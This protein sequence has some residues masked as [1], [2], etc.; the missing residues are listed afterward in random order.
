MPDKAEIWIRKWRIYLTLFLTGALFVGDLIAL[1]NTYLNGEI[2]T[3][4]I[5]KVIIILFI[6]GAIFKYYFFSIN[7]NIKWPT[8]KIIPSFGIIFVLIAIVMG[9]I[10]VGSPSKQRAIRFDE[11]RMQ[12]LFVIQ[13]KIISYWIA[14]G[15]LPDSL[16]KADTMDPAPAF[17]SSIHNDPV[18]N[19]PYEYNKTTSN[20]YELCATFDVSSN[21]IKKSQ[22][23][24]TVP[25]TNME[26]SWDHNIGRTCFVRTVDTNRYPLAPNPKPSSLK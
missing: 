4:F 10:T 15:V 19:K 17:G 21:E 14:Y 9:F 12:D 8:K 7:E 2:S 23:M 3:R 11:Q 1:I 26:L 20:S 18:T 25:D 13:S 16:I 6:A 24:P 5:L 22:G